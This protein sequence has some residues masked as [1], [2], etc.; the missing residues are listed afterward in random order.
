[1]GFRVHFRQKSLVELSKS[2][3]FNY[4]QDELAQVV[5]YYCESACV[6]DEFGTIL[7][8]WEIPIDEVES[9]IAQLKEN[10]TL[11][12]DMDEVDANAYGANDIIAFFQDAVD[13]VKAHPENYNHPDWLYL[14]WA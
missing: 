1:M 6:D 4:W 10:P 14:D 5:Q 8:T 7:N 9:M 11:P 2:A 3:K 12:I 13:W